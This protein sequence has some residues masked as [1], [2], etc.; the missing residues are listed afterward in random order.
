VGLER[1]GTKKA[2]NLLDAL[3]KSKTRDLSSFLFALGIPNTGKTTTKE[4][5]DHYRSL[6]GVMNATREELQGLPDIGG[7]VADSIVTFFQD[8]LMRASID[9]MLAN[10]VAPHAEEKAAPAD[11]SGFFYGKTV[12][13]T[14]TLPNLSRDD[15]GKLLEAAGAK[16]T[17]S[18]SKKTDVV[19]A[20]ESAGSKLTKA[21]D[22]GI[23]IIDNE[24][25]LYRLLGR[26]E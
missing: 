26:T 19:V 18:V 9:K 15:A 11:T 1:F 14:G 16:V 20:G 17:G 24:E 6:E 5:A 21:Q 23:R 12:V 22:L 13:L 8:E 2:K 3:E 25:E 10:G 4:L 7:I